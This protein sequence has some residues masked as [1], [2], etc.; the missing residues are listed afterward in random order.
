MTPVFDEAGAARTINE[1][2]VARTIN[3]AGAA[4]MP[5]AP[6]SGMQGAVT[7]DLS[8]AMADALI[9][10]V[11]DEPL[12]RTIIEALLRRSGFTNVAAVGDGRVAL[13]F[14]EERPP[15]C[16]LLDVM[17]PGLDGIE[18]CRRL[19][20]DPRFAR[21]PVIVQ[22]A[23]AGREDRRRAFNAGASDVVAKPYDP[24]ELEARV[25]VHLTRALLSEELLD[26]RARLEGELAE[27]RGLTEAV[28]PQPG[29]L[30]A[31]AACGVAF[32]HHHR[33]CSAIGGDYW[34]AWSA[35]DGLVALMVADVSGHGV[36]AALRMFALHALIMPPP[37]FAGDPAAFAAHLDRRLYGHGGSRGL[38]VA[39]F[40]GIID[41][42]RRRF[43]FVPAGMRDGLILHRGG[44][45]D[46]LCLSGLPF[47]VL[48][49]DDRSVGAVDLAPGDTLL[50][51]SDA[52]VECE[53]GDG[54]EP[55]SEEDLIAWLTPLLPV[56][57]PGPHL[58]P[59]LA[60]R[61]LAEFGRLVNDDL[62]VVTAGLTP[63]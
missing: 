61:F 23:M 43:R 29:A 35:G 30:A 16:V 36:S 19:R 34:H 28:L 2:G 39:G 62:L 56:A 14:I 22:T 52:L 40:C 17:M 32:G 54:R 38:Y 11:D 33:S 15:A 58:A 57:P 45:L 51:Y 9:L 10:V 7:T 21:V 8:A 49:D 31:L 4:R 50:F 24:M 53:P 42:R 60:E 1:A 27:A 25:R 12:N 46:R 3:D 5:H 6:G 47:G 63:D 13:A 59:W 37:P 20:A 26:Y 48:P 41:V 44:G 18:V 55:Q